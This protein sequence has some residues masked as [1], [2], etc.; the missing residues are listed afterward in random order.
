VFVV[1]ALTVLSGLHYS[2]LIARQLS[3]GQAG[4]GK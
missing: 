1:A 4:A 2:V 3:N